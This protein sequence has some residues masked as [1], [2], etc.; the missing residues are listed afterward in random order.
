MF[1]RDLVETIPADYGAVP[2]PPTQTVS[3]LWGA[4]VSRYAVKQLLTS[5]V[6][7]IRT[8]RSVGA[9]GGQPPLA[10]RWHRAT[11]V[12]TAIANYQLL[13]VGSKQAAQLTANVRREGGRKAHETAV[14][15]IIPIR[16]TTVVASRTPETR[17]DASAPVRL[18]T[19][20]A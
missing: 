13:C 5:V 20:P 12:P 1:S 2:S 17:F 3:A 6:R 7:E 19:T 18:K 8:L 15:P 11:G 16:Y 10:T 4:A 14:I 9:G